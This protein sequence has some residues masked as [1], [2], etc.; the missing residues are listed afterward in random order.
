MPHILRDY[1]HLDPCFPGGSGVL[2]AQAVRSQV[3]NTRLSIGEV[4]PSC[5]GSLNE[6]SP[7][8]VGGG[9]FLWASMDYRLL[10]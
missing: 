4:L 3:R 5:L 9:P 6:G 7:F 10:F 1:T 2:V 8:Y